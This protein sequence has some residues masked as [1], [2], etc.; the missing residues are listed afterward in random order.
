M[1]AT[2]IAAYLHPSMAYT[3]HINTYGEANL[4]LALFA[5]TIPGILV[6]FKHLLFKWAIS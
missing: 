5:L 3:V 6:C 1:I 2:F 4:E